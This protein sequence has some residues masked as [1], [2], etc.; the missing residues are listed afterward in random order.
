MSLFCNTLELVNILM[1]LGFIPG[2]CIDTA[3]AMLANLVNHKN[4]VHVVPHSSFCF[5]YFGGGG[6][7]C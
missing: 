6:W 1:M 7:G 5:P 2:E 4:Y 3:L